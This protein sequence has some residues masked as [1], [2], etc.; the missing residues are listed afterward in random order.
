M[1]TATSSHSSDNIGDEEREETSHR[2]NS[3]AAQPHEASIP[4][5]RQLPSSTAAGARSKAD[6]NSALDRA[7]EL[8][9]RGEHAERNDCDLEAA[10]RYRRN[11]L[12][13]LIGELKMAE[14]GTARRKVLQEEC[15]RLLTKTEETKVR[16]TELRRQFTAPPSSWPSGEGVSGEQ[17][18]VSLVAM[19]FPHADAKRALV[20]SGGNLDGALA[21]LL[22]QL[23]QPP[24]EQVQSTHQQAPPPPQ[25]VP[26]SPPLFPL[27]PQFPKA[28]ANTAP[29]P[30]PP[31]AM[32]RSSVPAYPPKPPRVV[33]EP[34]RPTPSVP[35]LARS[36]SNTNHSAVRKGGGVSA[37]AGRGN[38]SGGRGAGKSSTIP[39]KAAAANTT[40]SNAAPAKASAR[41]PQEELILQNC[42]EE[43]SSVQWSDIVGL[44]YAK[45]S[46]QEVPL[47]WRITVSSP[48]FLRPYEDK[49][50]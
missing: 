32:P 21:A 2:V 42:L 22:G 9:Q 48:F 18:M 35:P 27:P 40:G 30:M 7:V 47:F 15:E 1:G 23:P 25:H 41:S 14:Q 31:A 50:C 20:E 46:L 49:L 29:P 39:A 28:P 36:R 10:L 13:I 45:E 19:G 37:S 16:L 38:K 12:E 33:S 24:S 4:P 5:P 6:L 11:A 43:I 3:G 34:A 44:D 17:A 26:P 8:V